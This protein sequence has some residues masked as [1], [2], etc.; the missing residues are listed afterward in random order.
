MRQDS[1]EVT[2]DPRI[3][4]D[5]VLSRRL[6]AFSTIVVASVLLATVSAGTL[7]TV[8]EKNETWPEFASLVCMA[9]VF[10]MNLFCVMMITQQYYHVIRLIT[11]GPSGFDIAKSYYV[12]HNIRTIRHVA[13]NCFFYSIPLFLIAIGLM[14]FVKVGGAFKMAYPLTVLLVVSGVVFHCVLVKQRAL[15]KEKY[16]KLKAFEH[17]LVSHVQD[18][19]RFEG[20]FQSD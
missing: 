6:S 19:Q 15:F 13:T 1:V 8:N 3:F 5:S 10:A 16:A 7:I 17:P 12:N 9:L 4:L 2:N 20:T 14:V 18:M 11:S